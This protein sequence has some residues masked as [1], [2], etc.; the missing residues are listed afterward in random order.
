VRRADQ[1]AGLGLFLLGVAF[2]WAGLRNYT[3]W[4]PTGP[5]SGFLPFW[6]GLAMAVLAAWLLIGA[7]RARAVGGRWL[8]EGAGLRRLATVM[9]VT[10]ALVA[11]LKIVGMAVGTVLFLVVILRFVEHLRWPSTVAIAAGTAAVNYLIFT[12][13]LRVPFP[14]GLL[15][16]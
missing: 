5:G 12:Y 16:F 14:V 10:V 8:P 4:G 3:Y 15:G 7:T 13:W 6:L 1:I 11:V 9:G 2:A